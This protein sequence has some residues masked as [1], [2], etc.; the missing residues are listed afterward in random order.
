MKNTRMRAYGIALF[1]ITSLLSARPFEEQS[2]QFNAGP[3]F[4]FARYKFSN[5]NVDCCSSS[6]D[7][8]CDECPF[9]HQQGYLAGLH[10]DL[11]HTAPSHWYFKLQFDGRWNAGYVCG[12]QDTRLQI[13]DYRP[14]TDFGYSFFFGE[15]EHSVTPFIGLGFN[16]LSAEFKHAIMTNRYFNL[17]VPL[18][19]NMVWNVR[20]EEFNVGLSFEYRIDAWTRLK[21]DTN[22][23]FACD[24]GRCPDDCT[25]KCDT[26]CKTKKDCNFKEKV[27]K[28][29]CCDSKKS[30]NSCEEVCDDRITL[31]RSHGFHVE[32]PMTWYHTWNDK[33]NFQTRV[34]PFFDWNRFGASC[35]A[36]CNSTRVPVP[37]S[38]R[39]YLGLHI[40]L[41]MR[42]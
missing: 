22:D 9:P 38:D 35:E 19:M 28:P 31:K 23:G 39:W 13:K 17:Y 1:S 32:L 42:F 15:K 21:V 33:V 8:A 12:K 20:P 26:D 16:Y 3:E 11:T 14:E 30:C 41:G 40:D 37:Q 18:G 34:V 29:E 5:Q 2:W 27:Y 7:T 24:N 10:L 36:S 25:K 6:C 4:N